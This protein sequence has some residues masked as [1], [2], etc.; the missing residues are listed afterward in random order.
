MLR[1][2]TG[3]L[4]LAVLLKERVSIAALPLGESIS[5][6][7]ANDSHVQINDASVSRHHAVIHVG[8]PMRLED[9]GSKNGVTLSRQGD[10][11]IKVFREIVNLAPGDNLRIGKVTAV[12][13]RALSP[14][15]DAREGEGARHPSMRALFVKA[16]YVASS[17][18]DVLVVGEPGSGRRTLAKIVHDAS[19][20]RE[21]PFVVA[22]PDGRG[23]RDEAAF[24]ALLAAADGG[25]LCLHEVGE[26]AAEERLSLLR[27][28]EAH[29][30]RG[31]GNKG[32][33]IVSTTQRDLTAKGA[34]ERE[35]YAVLAEIPLSVPPLRDRISEVPWLST[36]FVA[37]ACRA[38]DRE[39]EPRIQPDALSALRE[40]TYPGNVRELRDIIERAVL[41][42]TGDA[43]TLDHL[44]S[45]LVAGACTMTWP[46]EI[47]EPAREE[48][49]PSAPQPQ[50]HREMLDVIERKETIEALTRSR[51][52]R[53]QAAKELG[54]SRRTMVNRIK[55]HG[56]RVEPEKP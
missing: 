43:I 42:S 56:I 39:G 48:E 4:H 28:L 35:L 46:G 50:R 45:R 25:T 23:R 24:G 32:L 5:I 10:R 31:R 12:V 34:F 8:P 49:A 37:D 15:V 14:S 18:L 6:G 52:N 27:A 53:T 7:R 2:G 21:G 38:I 54:I 36:I 1:E 47:L 40:H 51:G 55:K 33:R 19:P 30:A 16:H 26:L 9:L 17:T 41:L 44:P 3:A 13:R 11:S 20:R 22:E 29:R